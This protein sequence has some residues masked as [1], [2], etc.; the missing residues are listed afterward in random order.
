MDEETLKEAYRAWSPVVYR[1]ALQLLRDE[2]EAF[3]VMQ[4]VFERLVEGRH[5][6]AE[7]RALLLWMYRVTTNLCLNRIRDTRRRAALLVTHSG[8]VP[9]GSTGL[10]AARVDAARTI[11][12]VAERAP[13]RELRA[14]VYCYVDG[15]TQE[16][17][18]DLLGVTSRTIRNLL[19]RFERRAEQTQQDTKETGAESTPADG[20]S[21]RGQDTKL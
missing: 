17:A 4:D 12:R 14:A 19:R 6:D 21:K 18:A 9:T 5:R 15:M 8:S 2:D 1:R 13:E 11:A 20:S 7:G 16:E 3:D 10:S